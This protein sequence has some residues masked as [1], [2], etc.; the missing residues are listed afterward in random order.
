MR[1]TLPKKSTTVPDNAKK[2]F[3]GKIFDVFQWEQELYDGSKATFE[4]LKRPDTIQVIA[5]KD[6]QIVILRDEQPG[7]GPLLCLPGGRPEQTDASWEEAAK[8]ELLEETGMTFTSWKLI[9]VEQ[10][11]RKIEWF[12]PVYLATDFESQGE[13]TL[14]VGGEKIEVREVPF[15]N[16]KDIVFGDEDPKLKY[17]RGFLLNINTLEEL[18]AIP[19]YQGNEIDRD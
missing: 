2:V 19:E 5:L 18:L 15:Q 9:N 3:S 11:V 16:F 17:L 14:D 13:Q 1:K 4:M 6:E 8:R 7:R 12:G 10:P